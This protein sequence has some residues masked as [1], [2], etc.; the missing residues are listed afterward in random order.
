MTVCVGRRIREKAQTKLKRDK[1]GSR[2]SK[3]ARINLLSYI[4]NGNDTLRRDMCITVGSSASVCSKII[5]LTSHAKL[6][7][8]QVA[9]V[10]IH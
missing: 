4:K 9:D 3:V 5:I 8:E 2:Y 1:E 6:C 10:P 7:L